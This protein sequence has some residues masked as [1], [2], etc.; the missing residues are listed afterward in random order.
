MFSLANKGYD[1]GTVDGLMGP[2]TRTAIK[3]YHEM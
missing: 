2:N 3:A 1:P